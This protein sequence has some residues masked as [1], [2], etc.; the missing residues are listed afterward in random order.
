MPE[1]RRRRAIPTTDHD[2]ISLEA[3]A[4]KRNS[5]QARSLLY[6]AILQLPYFMV[7]VHIWLALITLAWRGDVHNE[8]RELDALLRTVSGALRAHD[9]VHWVAPGGELRQHGARRASL[10]RYHRSLTFGAQHGQELDVAAALSDH[11]SLSTVETHSGLRI[12]TGTPQ[13]GLDHREPYVD[14]RYYRND[15][16][17]LVSDCCG[18]DSGTIAACTKRMCACRACVS[19]TKSIH[20]ISLLRLGAQTLPAPHDLSSVWLGG[21]HPS[22]LL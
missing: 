3:P 1:L 10:T 7:V 12:F 8:P 20:P 16:Q 22:A 11:K 21:A 9:I 4:S 6:H 17:L 13:H 5:A 2:A 18:C 14:I 19:L 15:G